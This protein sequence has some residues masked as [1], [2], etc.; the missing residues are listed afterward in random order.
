MR[1]TIELS[2]DGE[3]ALRRL[4]Q[5]AGQDTEAL[6]RSLAE[7]ALAGGTDANSPVLSTPGVMGGDACVRRTRVPIWML[8]GY[9]GAG[10]SDERILAN[11]PGLTAADLIAAWDYNA[12]HGERV[13][14]ER[15]AHEEVE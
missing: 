1:H 8:V 5:E 2:E 7:A 13:R 12:S 3:A 9:K 15:R 4:A 6:L 11:F 14:A 10:Y